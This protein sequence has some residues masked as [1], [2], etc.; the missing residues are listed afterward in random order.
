MAVL[1]LDQNG[2][3]DRG[4]VP[5]SFAN[6]IS[7]D[8]PVSDLDVQPSTSPGDPS[9]DHWSLSGA[10]HRENH[11]TNICGIPTKRTPQDNITDEPTEERGH[12]RDGVETSG[13]LDHLGDG[14]QQ[15]EQNV[16]AFASSEVAPPQ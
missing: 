10:P 16:S 15:P 3:D 14:L 13:G 8:A 11:D 2:I 7:N 5:G 6:I 1:P 9:I 12:D 4:P